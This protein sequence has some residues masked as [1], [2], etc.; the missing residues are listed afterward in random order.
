MPET[1]QITLKSGTQQHDW[2]IPA[3]AADS[4]ARYMQAQLETVIEEVDDGGLR[5]LMPVERPKYS[6][7]A[8]MIVQRMID[9]LIEPALAQFPPPAIAQLKQQAEAAAQAVS[10]ARKAVAAQIARPKETK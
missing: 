8:E 7:T 3:E 1:I 6:S 10:D 4:L 5:R 9:S 2:T